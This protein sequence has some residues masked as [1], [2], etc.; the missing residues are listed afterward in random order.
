MKCHNMRG[1]VINKQNVAIYLMYST[2]FWNN[3]HE[4]CSSRQGQINLIKYL[5]Q[6]F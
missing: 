5:L 2:R 1:I 4:V 6:N 3:L